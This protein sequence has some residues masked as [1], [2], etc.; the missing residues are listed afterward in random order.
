M[1]CYGHFYTLITT[2]NSPLPCRSVLEITT[3]HPEKPK[4]LLK[5]QPDA[6][7]VMMNPGS[8]MPKRAVNQKI[9]DPQQIRTHCRLVPAKPDKTQ[10]QI[11]EI[12][13]QM[14][15]SHIRVLNLSDI[16]KPKISKFFRTIHQGGF[17]QN[18]HIQAPHSVFSRKRTE[19]LRRRMNPCSRIIIAGWGKS[20]K[21]PKWR[22]NIAKRCYDVIREFGFNIIGYPGDNNYDHIFVHPFYK[23]IMNNWTDCI[24]SQIRADLRNRSTGRQ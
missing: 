8:S 22:N 24:V 6:V 20:W 19:E 11:M 1:Y 13:R 14:D 23:P 17:M 5:Q 16:R 7:V 4:D 9:R 2:D 15:Y 18:H 21:K 3:N 12:M 10:R